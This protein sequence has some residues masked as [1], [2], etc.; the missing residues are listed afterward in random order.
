MSEIQ[1]ILLTEWAG[2]PLVIWLAGIVLFVF[3]VGRVRVRDLRIKFKGRDREIL[4][5]TDHA[6][7]KAKRDRRDE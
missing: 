5:E 2:A 7:T 4:L 6:V 3:I 1:K